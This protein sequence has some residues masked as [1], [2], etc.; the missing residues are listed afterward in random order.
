ML[1]D[2]FPVCAILGVGIVLT[3]TGG[4]FFMN[5]IVLLIVIK[6]TMIVFKFSDRN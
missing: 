5:G 3:G 4:L 2:C 1:I 6:A